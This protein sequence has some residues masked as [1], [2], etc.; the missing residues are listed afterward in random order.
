MRKNLQ[1]V[2]EALAAGVIE[3]LLTITNL[4]SALDYIARDRLYQVPRGIESDIKIIGIDAKTLGE[5]GRIDTWSRSI[6]ADLINKLCVDDNTKPAVIGFDILFSSGITG[7]DGDQLFADAASRH[8]NVV[9][10]NQLSYS[11]KWETDKNG[12]LYYPVNGVDNPYAELFDAASVGYCNVSQDSDGTVRRIIPAEVFEGTEYHSFATVMYERYCAEM[13]ITPN[14]IPTDITGRTMINYSGKPGDYEY[15]S[16]SDVLN[17]NI[18]PRIFDDSI[19]FVGAY[20]PEMM[21]DFN[22]PNGGSSQMYGVEIHAN[23]FQ[24][25]ATL[26]FWVS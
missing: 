25:T 24:S 21:D 8:G 26:I 4:F 12:V 23:I 2:L 7:N 14:N 1:P 16:M 15:I 10:V 13:G 9:V 18:D 3:F 11:K 19:V 6:Y 22:V 20:D 17:G 5:Y